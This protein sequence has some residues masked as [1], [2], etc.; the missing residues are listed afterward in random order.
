[1]HRVGK[2]HTSMHIC[3]NC[4][5]SETIE[6]SETTPSPH[7]LVEVLAS[8]PLPGSVIPLYYFIPF[9]SF[10]ARNRNTKFK[11]QGSS[12]K[13]HINFDLGVLGE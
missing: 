5:A 2:G 1:M 10:H 7:S 8:Y 4:L 9:S 3:F 11:Y 13:Y 6:F 12:K